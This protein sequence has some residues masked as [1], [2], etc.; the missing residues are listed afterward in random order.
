MVALSVVAFVLSD[1]DPFAVTVSPFASTDPAPEI[2]PL[3]ALSVTFLGAVEMPAFT[4]PDTVR[5]PV[6]TRT[7]TSPDCVETPR[8]LSGAFTTTVRALPTPRM[9]ADRLP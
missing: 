9:L 6:S 8:M 4:G 7:L 1:D 2:V 3:A 5:L